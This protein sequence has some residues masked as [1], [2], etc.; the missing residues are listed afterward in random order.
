VKREAEDKNAKADGRLAPRRD[1][2][3]DDEDPDRHREG[4]PRKRHD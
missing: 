3:K 2:S 1:R 4:Q